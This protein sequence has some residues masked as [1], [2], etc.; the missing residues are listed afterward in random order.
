[1]L[2][3]DSDLSEISDLSDSYYHINGNPDGDL[4]DDI[5]EHNI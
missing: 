1:M 5:M 2:H 3:D 4:D